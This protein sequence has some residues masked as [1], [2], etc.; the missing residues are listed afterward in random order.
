M[1]FFGSSPIN[2]IHKAIQTLCLGW[3]P[4][5]SFLSEYPQRASRWAQSGNNHKCQISCVSTSKAETRQEHENR[6]AQPFNWARTHTH[7]HTRNGKKKNSMTIWQKVKPISLSSQVFSNNPH[8]GEESNKAL[9]HSF[10]YIMKWSASVPQGN[11]E[12][13]V[14]RLRER[15]QVFSEFT[16]LLNQT[17]KRVH[18]EI[19][20]S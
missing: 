10:T 18:P 2:A 4:I 20:K 1:T 3:N 9:I 7:T 11:F 12:C 6:H 14:N 8:L 16:I 5:K 19:S 17:L 15:V 13:R